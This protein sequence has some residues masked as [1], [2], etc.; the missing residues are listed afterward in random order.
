MVLHAFEELLMT[1]AARTLGSGTPSGVVNALGTLLAYDAP[2]SGAA[3]ANIT[4][5]TNGTITY[6]GDGSTGVTNWYLPTTTA[7]GSSYWI[8]FTTT[9]G[10]PWTVGGLTS[11][12]IYALSSNRQVG[13]VQLV[14][15]GGK[16]GTAS[17]NIYGDSGGTILLGSGTISA[18]VLTN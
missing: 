13:W 6:V 10:V 2:V 1:F 7:I 15:G 12:T 11:G 17:V 8:K 4:F 16:T 14:G 9:S 18:Q 3:A 5:N